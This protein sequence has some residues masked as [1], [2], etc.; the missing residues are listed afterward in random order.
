M[1]VEERTRANMP[2]AS[3]LEKIK[4][5]DE[6]GPKWIIE[7][8][9]AVQD[10]E[11]ER[12]RLRKPAEH[13]KQLCAA[14]LRGAA[15]VFGIPVRKPFVDINPATDAWSSVA[16][17][18]TTVGDYIRMATR[19]YMAQNN[20]TAENLGLTPEEI[21]GLDLVIVQNKAYPTL[22]L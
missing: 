19:D 9:K 20:L 10:E 14:F 4:A 8:M 22:D 15:S 12:Q 13:R 1:T 18:W 3:I 7:R 21:K 5:I 16:N 17:T 11:Q 2:P 6:N